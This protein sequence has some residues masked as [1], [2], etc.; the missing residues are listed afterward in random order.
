MKRWS[1]PTHPNVGNRLLLIL[2]TIG[3]GKTM[4]MRTLKVMV[5]MA[6][7]MMEVAPSGMTIMIMVTIGTPGGKNGRMTALTTE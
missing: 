5:A 3:P 2:G 6:T 7:T 4:T 1:L